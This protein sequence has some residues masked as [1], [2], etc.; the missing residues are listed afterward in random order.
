MDTRINQKDRGDGLPARH[1]GQQRDQGTDHRDDAGGVAS[2][3]D[4][5]GSIG[6]GLSALHSMLD[7]MRAEQG[8]PAGTAGPPPPAL[9]G[10]V[11]GVAHAGPGKAAPMPDTRAALKDHHDLFALLRRIARHEI[12][13]DE[14]APA[15]RAPSPT[16]EAP[17]PRID[18]AVGE[19]LFLGKLRVPPA[20]PRPRARTGSGF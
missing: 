3:L 15:A 4:R 9:A 14:T 11:A 5:L 12:A 10:T 1:S 7:A 19:H 13:R 6:D 2:F 20:S 16:I 8:R 17:P 18:L